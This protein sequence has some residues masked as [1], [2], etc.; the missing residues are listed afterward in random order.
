MT[1]PWKPLLNDGKLDALVKE[2]MQAFN[3]LSP[4]EQAAHRRDQAISWA[5]G[6]LLC[7]YGE[8]AGGVTEEQIAK[9]YDEKNGELK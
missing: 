7:K 3:S 4:Q 9:M 5:Y 1:I 8:G 6:N 2:A